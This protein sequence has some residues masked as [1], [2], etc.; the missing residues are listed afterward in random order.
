M[1]SNFHSGLLDSQASDLFLCLIRDEAL[2]NAEKHE[3]I[4]GKPPTSPVRR[5]VW[6]RNSRGIRLKSPVSV[7]YGTNEESLASTSPISTSASLF[8]RSPRRPETLQS[9]SRKLFRCC[10]SANGF[11]LPGDDEVA[12]AKQEK[13][14]GKPAGSGSPGLLDR[15]PRRGLTLL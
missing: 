2:E 15:R 9:P 13:M 6:K 14:V 3:S 7:P 1:V 5:L 8:G 11:G 4:N 12:T 10:K